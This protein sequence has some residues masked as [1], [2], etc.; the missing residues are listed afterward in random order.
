MLNLSSLDKYQSSRVLV[1][2][3]TGSTIP[4]FKIVQFNGMGTA[5]PQVTV[6][7]P[8]SPCF[9]LTTQPILNASTGIIYSFGFVYA[10]N[11]SA[12]SVGV[13]LYSDVTGSLVTSPINTGDQP[14]ALVI[15]QDSIAGILYVLIQTNQY[16]GSANVTLSGDVTGAGTNSISTIISN[17]VV[18]NAKMAKM[19]ATTIK[20]NSTASLANAADLTAAQVTAML[21]TFVGDTGTG[22]TQG[23]VPAPAATTSWQSYYL[24]ANGSFSQV[25]QSKPNYPSFQLLSQTSQPTALSKLNGIAILG[26]YAYLA[27]TANATLS[28][29]DISNQNKPVL[30]SVL[31][32]GTYGSYGVFPFVQGGHTYVAIP[33]SGAVGKLILVNVDNPNTPTITTTFT[34]SSSPITVGALYSCCVYNGYIYIASQSAGLLVLDIGGGSG[35]ISTPV[36]VFQESTVLNAIKSFGVTVANGTLFTTQYITS[37]FSTRQIKSWS[38]TTPSTPSLLQSLQVTTVGEPLGVVVSG[39]TAFVAVT[40]GSGGSAIDLIDVTSPSSMSNLSVANASYTF[41]SGMLPAVSGNYLFVPS[42]TNA[43]N[44]GA[45]DFFDISTRT[46]PVKIA[47]TYTGVGGSVFGSI[48]INNGYIYA[49]DY[50]VAPGSNGS[51]DV[52]SMPSISLIAGSITVSKVNYNPATPTNWSST[53]PTTIQQALDRMAALLV[54]LNSGTPIP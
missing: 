6:G 34:F 33:S 8:S 30:K 39:N 50:G 26:N 47:T 2:N 42:G 35:S 37:G 20:G 49:A 51:L 11:T 24:S 28:I 21:S 29:Y 4:A 12:W 32:S 5:Y 16:R 52:F 14:I 13:L 27:G 18:T 19:A 54:T 40:G 17:N 3:N 31:S 22:G 36:A 25:D 45:I 9:G 7:S 44:G 23:L 48:T 41:S 53:A 10:I 46:S 15:N 38:I 43:T 1:E